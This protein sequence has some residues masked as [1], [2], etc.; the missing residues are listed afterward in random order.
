M[1]KPSPQARRP[2]SRVGSNAEAYY[3]I[4]C[5]M[6][7][8]YYVYSRYSSLHCLQKEQ[9]CT[10]HMS[11]PSDFGRLHWD[12]SCDFDEEEGEGWGRGGGVERVT[13]LLYS[14]FVFWTLAAD[15]EF[16]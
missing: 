1:I 9:P 12:V 4:V 15:F 6:E 11:V 10:L 13:V 2:T 5:N 8:R 14:D 3:L 16:F 7:T